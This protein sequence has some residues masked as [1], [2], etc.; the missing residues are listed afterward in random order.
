[1]TFTQTINEIIAEVMKYG[2]DTEQRLKNLT[3]KLKIAFIK[4]TKSELELQGQIREQLGKT[5]NKLLNQKNLVHPEVKSFTLQ[6]IKPKLRAELEKRILASA[7]LIKYRKEESTAR[8]LKD[9]QGWM[10]SVPKGG[11][12]S[13]AV[14]KQGNKLKKLTQTENYYQRRISIDQASKLNSAIKEIVAVDEGAIAGIWHSKGEDEPNY[15]AR[16]D[17]LERARKIYIVRDSWAD[18]QGFI[19]PIWGYT[20]E[21]TK[22]AEEV[23]CRCSYQYI[24]SLR[25]LPEDYLTVKGK[26]ALESA[27][28][29][30]L[31]G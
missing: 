25:K 29:Q 10:T 8:V 18:K 22:P 19:K 23:N 11:T 2:F 15:D 6:S 30:L 16:Q 12:K 1:M 21:I 31:N 20:D 28:K 14:K 26:N 24:F 3:F 7:D 4:S 9:F 17:H 13:P 27:K 5:F